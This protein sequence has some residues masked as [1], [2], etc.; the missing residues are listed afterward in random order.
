MARTLLLTLV[1][2]LSLATAQTPLSASFDG[3]KVTFR[4]AQN[5]RYFADY[6]AGTLVLPDATL[7]DLKTTFPKDFKVKL[8]EDFISISVG[9]NFR[10]S[11]SPNEKMLTVMR[12]EVLGAPPTQVAEDERAPVMY[13]LS[14]ADP[15]ETATLLKGI[16]GELPIQVD[17]RQ[18]ALLILVNPN[19]RELLD[20]TVTALDRARPQV[21]FE[22]EI[23]EINQDVTESLG[24][25]YDS[26][27][28]FNLTEGAP[29]GILKMGAFDR[30]PLSLNF[31]LNLLK[32]NGAADVLA[33]PRVT[34]M[35]GVQ[36]QLNATQTVPVIVPGANGQEGVQNI[37]TGIQLTLTPKISPDG[38]VEADLSISVSTPTGTTSQGV[39]QFSS[40]EANTT[41]RVGNGE[42]IAIG[43]LL[44]QRTI[45]GK[46]KVPVL[47]DIPLL[48]ALFTST[49]TEYRKTDLVIVVTPRIVDTKDLPSYTAEQ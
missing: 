12:G 34:T 36:A 15:G 13:Y 45:E 3:E 9:G 46:Q 21:M 43:G 1:F 16:F 20:K 2:V 23:L 32:T 8:H 24:I 6:E 38:T 25:N 31:G 26:I 14:N 39:P 33:R 42:P 41:V 7:P 4:S 19:D 11:L 18:R 27:F 17:V 48:G 5:I 35:D 40:R 37:T 30:G 28:T 29:E 22:A 10:V 49:R 47:G 44:E